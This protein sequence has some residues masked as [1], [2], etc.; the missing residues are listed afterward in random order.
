MKKQNKKEFV[1]TFYKTKFIKNVFFKKQNKM[2]IS[3]VT[4]LLASSLN[5]FYLRDNCSMKDLITYANMVN[6]HI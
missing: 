3:P 1:G 5:V 6:P 4:S 2:G